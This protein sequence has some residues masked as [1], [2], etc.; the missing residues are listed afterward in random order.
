MCFCG[1]LGLN[2]LNLALDLGGLNILRLKSLDTLG[3]FL[4]LFQISH[5]NI[6]KF[7]MIFNKCPKKI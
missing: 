1:E 5:I 3:L 4:L 2:H 7:L 6:G